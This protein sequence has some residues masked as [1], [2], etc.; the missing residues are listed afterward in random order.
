MNMM[1]PGTNLPRNVS[2]SIMQATFDAPYQFISTTDNGNGD[3]YPPGDTSSIGSNNNSP[4]SMSL[5]PSSSS[6]TATA[7]TPSNPVPMA[8]IASKSSHIS[9]QPKSMSTSS[10]PVAALY[11][12][13]L[14][15]SYSTSSPSLL[16]NTL[17]PTSN[18]PLYHSTEDNHHVG[19][20]LPI[21]SDSSSLSS[22]YTNSIYNSSSSMNNSNISYSMSNMS[23]NNSNNKCS[24]NNS[25][26]R[27]YDGGSAPSFQLP[28]TNS[29]TTAMGTASSQPRVSMTSS[30]LSMMPNY[31]RMNRSGL[32]SSSSATMGM[33]DGES[34]HGVSFNNNDNNNMYANS[35]NRRMTI[36]PSGSS[37]A[38]PTTSS[39]HQVPLSYGMNVNP[40][41]GTSMN[42]AT[43]TATST[44]S[45]AASTFGNNSNVDMMSPTPNDDHSSSSEKNTGT[46][47]GG[48]TEATKPPFSYATLIQTAIQSSP[49]KQLTLSEIYNWITEHFDYYK[50]ANPGWKNSIRHNL[51]L[52]KCFQKVPRPFNE[53]GKGSYW[54]YDESAAAAA[55]SNTTTDTTETSS[56]TSTSLASGAA[57]SGSSGTSS[58]FTK[59]RTRRRAL[60]EPPAMN[61]AV[62]HND[63]PLHSADATSSPSPLPNTALVGAAHNSLTSPS[64]SPIPTIQ[65]AFG[66]PRV[67][68]N[69]RTRAYS[70]TISK[71]STT[72]PVTTEEGTVSG[73]GSSRLTPTM[74]GLNFGAPSSTAST[75]NTAS[76]YHHASGVPYASQPFV[77]G[78]PNSMGGSQP[79]F[80]TD[81]ISRFRSKPNVLPTLDESAPLDSSRPIPLSSTT[82]GLGTNNPV[83]L[84]AT[85]ATTTRTTTASASAPAASY[86]VPNS[87]YGMPGTMKSTSIPTSNIHLGANVHVTNS[88]GVMVGLNR[89]YDMQ[90]FPPP[91]NNDNNNNFHSSNI[92]ANNNADNT[93]GVSSTVDYENSHDT[94]FT[95]P[96]EFQDDGYED[97]AINS[98]SHGFHTTT[99]LMSSS[100]SLYDDPHDMF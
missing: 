89:G 59:L 45:A 32:V 83:P 51:S 65:G 5:S 10:L 82:S 90:S 38:A 17:A 2:T 50:T 54:I 43:T 21:P 49:N 9:I 47:P 63:S 76:P 16:N 46:T 71:R 34:R 98:E 62:L 66:P 19:N 55:A 97:Y 52:N 24:D 25:I 13:S 68:R 96:L 20:H 48:G 69:G 57:T 30:S 42:V 41:V 80:N 84:S 7:T 1:N 8:T 18:I 15:A 85:T 88:K 94:V 53:P 95:D 39:L 73:S 26:G 33:Y 60:S 92:I 22:S 77:C 14:P 91:V 70:Y 87:S 6:A 3:G 56:P 72:I 58:S 23:M 61:P 81:A 93:I 29:A 44:M 86:N 100:G 35:N 74:A 27:G 12:S 67:N 75:T 78:D 36:P 79:I 40:T 37:M 64:R 28:M 4:S 31:Q 99:T 11:S